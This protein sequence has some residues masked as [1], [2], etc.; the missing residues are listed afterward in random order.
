VPPA[1]EAGAVEDPGQPT[2]YA[3]LEVIESI[4]EMPKRL[5]LAGPVI[6]IGRTPSQCDIAFREDLT[7]SR[8]HANM[9][10]EGDKYRIF[11]EGST[12]GTWVNGRQVPEYGVELADGD[13]IHIGAVHLVFRQPQG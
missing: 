2:I 8:Q 3:S 11:D 9:M 10:L 6:R 4:T 13:E 12:S 7:V 5:D 1:E